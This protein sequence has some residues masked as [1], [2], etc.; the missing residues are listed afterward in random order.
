MRL[1]GPKFGL[2]DVGLRKF[3]QRLDVPAPPRGYWAKKQAG[4][5]TPV[6]AWQR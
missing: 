1:L 5:S 6:F 2:S 3:C 4:K